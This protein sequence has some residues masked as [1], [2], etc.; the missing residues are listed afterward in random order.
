M[1]DMALILLLGVSGAVVHSGLSMECTIM[2]DWSNYLVCPSDLVEV[3]C[4]G[5]H[6]L[7]LYISA[8]TH[9]C[10]ILGGSKAGYRKCSLF[11]VCW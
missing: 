10:N 8:L 1:V 5:L 6:W 3:V 2:V 7:S 11:M 9:Y 4:T